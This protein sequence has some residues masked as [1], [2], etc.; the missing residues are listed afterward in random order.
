MISNTWQD[1]GALPVDNQPMATDQQQQPEQKPKRSGWK[2]WVPMG[3]G[4]L[5]TL[6]AAPLTGGA[7]LAG[8]A[9]ILGAAG[10]IGGGAGEWA[11]QKL[12]NEKTDLKAI[13]KE[14]L[15]SGALSAI[16]LGRAGQIGK[17]VVA[18]GAERAGV[19]VAE[20]GAAGGIRNWVGSK[21][22]SAADDTALR[23]TQLSG[24]KEALKNFEKRFGEDLGAYIR[25][26]NLIGKTG[27]EVE[28]TVISGLNKKYADTVGKIERSITSSDV[29]AQN[30]KKGSSLNKLLTGASTE[31]KQLADDVF[32]ELDQIFK[33]EGGAITPQRLNEIK[34][35][36]QRLAKNAYKLGSNTKASVNEKVAEYL[37]KTLQGVSGTDDLARTGKE[38]DKAYKAADLLASASQNGRGTLS[39]GL[40]DAIVAAP[41]LAMG[42]IPAMVGAVGAKRA[43]NSPQV[44]SFIANKLGQAGEKLIAGGAKRAATETVVDNTAKGLIK[45]TAKDQI[46]GR[47][48]QALTTAGSAMQPNMPTMPTDPGMDQSQFDQIDQANLMALLT[49]GQPGASGSQYSEENLLADIQRDPK[50]MDQYMQL[51]EFL[52]P[53]SKDQKLNSTTA[54]QLASSANAENTLNQLEQLYGATG[55]GS[56]KIGGFIKSKM[57]GMGL[58]NETASY[59]A[60]AAS[61]VS[62]LA[63]ALNGGGQV[64]DAD[65]AV[66]I[67]ALPKVTDSPE[68]ARTKF[69]ALRARLQAAQQNTMRFGGAASGSDA[70]LQAIMGM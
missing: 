41:G 67:Q 20:R 31:N 26:N 40:T 13:A 45:Q 5:A 63:R 2:S 66:V 38:L 33:N 64:S 42:N 9:A 22:L 46:P 29:L 6:A 17:N 10:L 23:A 55:G 19:R 28:D 57:G 49:G 1:M 16:P 65:A 61:T 39:F 25:N 32:K 51:F 24:K 44:Q 37:K 35:E 8:T 68:V 54:T 62:Q 11:A 59:E 36:Y 27:K 60:L 30:M 70:E 56:G 47:T 52:N 3:A 58:N 53:Q 14:G 7:S 50:N 48:I 21:L 18:K 43:V 12:N 69:M 15:V 34:S 4:L